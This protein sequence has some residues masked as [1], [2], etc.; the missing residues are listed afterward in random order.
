V[1]L[2]VF[3]LAGALGGELLIEELAAA[4]EVRNIYIDPQT[5]RFALTDR[6]NL[7]MTEGLESIAQGLRCALSTYFAE[8]YL[9]LTLGVRWRETILGK[10]PNTAAVTEEL[11]KN[12][13][14]VPGVIAV[15]SINV[16]LDK[17]TRALTGSF[18]ATTDLG[19]LSATFIQPQQVGV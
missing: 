18:S 4:N 7:R 16:A 14:A 10:N 5:N 13:E 17:R 1:P 15:T 11:R 12:V 9:D 2:L 19:R 3:E 6:G 8:W